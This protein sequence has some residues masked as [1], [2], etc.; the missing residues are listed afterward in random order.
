M[1]RKGRRAAAEAGFEGRG[2]R[3]I[4]RGA[5][6]RMGRSGGVRGRWGSSGGLELVVGWWRT[7]YANSVS[8]DVGLKIPYRLIQWLDG[9]A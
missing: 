6:R 1:H 8:L 4:Q 3:R 7:E 9:Y 2:R 5:G